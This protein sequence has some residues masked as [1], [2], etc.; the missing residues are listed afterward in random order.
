[1]PDL[2]VAVSFQVFLS[3]DFC[4]LKQLS[5]PTAIEKERICE[6]VVPQSCNP[7]ILVPEQLNHFYELDGQNSIPERAPSLQHHDKA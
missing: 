4:I 6:G 2:F 5:Q 7:L 3:S 1:M